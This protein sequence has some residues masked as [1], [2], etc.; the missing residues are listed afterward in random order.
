M[1]ILIMQRIL[2][3][4]RQEPQ[5]GSRD[6]I[7]ATKISKFTLSKINVCM[8]NGGETDGIA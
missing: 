5:W 6:T 3:G 8:M 7:Q 1:G 2:P 4:A